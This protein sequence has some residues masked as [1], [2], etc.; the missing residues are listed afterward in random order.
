MRKKWI[1]VLAAGCLLLGLAGC[2]EK[3]F[4]RTTVEIK[5]NGHIVQ[6]IVEDF[7]EPYYDLEELQT[8]IENECGAYNE[9][10]GEKKAVAF[11]DAEEKDGVLTAKLEYKNAAAYAGFNKKALF[12][13]TIQE[14]YQSGYDLAVTLRSAQEDGK[15][16]G[17]AELLEMSKAHVLIIREAVDVRVW[18]K[19]LCYSDDVMPREDNSL[20]VTDQEMLTYIVFQ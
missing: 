16:V 5:K 9:A 12:C 4:D 10:A 7:S 2:G 13:G 3:E 1:L 6:T 14:A 17:K 15:T 8:T 19:V 18:D 11:L 20:R